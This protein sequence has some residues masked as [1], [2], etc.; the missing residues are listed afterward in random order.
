M[1]G[2]FRGYLPTKVSNDAAAPSGFSTSQ[3][4]AERTAGISE[5][6]ARIRAAEAA[7]AET[8]RVHAGG[9]IPPRARHPGGGHLPSY[10]DS[11]WDEGQIRG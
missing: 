6:E 5:A 7:R 8:E 4:K 1:S 9:P 11:D 2:S 10:P 3:A